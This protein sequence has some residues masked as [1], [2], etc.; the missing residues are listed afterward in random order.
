M[1]DPAIGWAQQRVPPGRVVV[2]Y[3]AGRLPDDA[4]PAAVAAV[5]T[6]AGEA[7]RRHPDAEQVKAAQVALLFIVVLLEEVPGELFDDGGDRSGLLLVAIGH[8]PEGAGRPA[9]WSGRVEYVY[10]H[11]GGR[12]D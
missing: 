10:R 7:V 12:R 6:M 11:W 1:S 3:A 9:G 2:G 8:I 5:A 4:S